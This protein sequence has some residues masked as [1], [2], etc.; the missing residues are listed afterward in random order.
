M[1]YCTSDSH[2]DLTRTGSARGTQPGLL[3]TQ[4]SPRRD[5]SREGSAPGDPPRRRPSASPD[6]RANRHT[7]PREEEASDHI[8]WP[9]HTRGSSAE[10]PVILLTTSTPTPRGRRRRRLPHND[11]HVLLGP[12]AR[13]RF[14]P[15]LAG[16][17]HAERG[18]R[19]A[20]LRRFVRDDDG[21]AAHPNRRLVAHR[22][23]GGVLLGK[24]DVAVALAARRLAPRGQPHVRDR[25]ALRSEHLA[26]VVFVRVVRQVADVNRAT[27]LGSRRGE[28][29][30]APVLQLGADGVGPAYREVPR[31]SVFD[32]GEPVARQTQRSLRCLGVGEINVRVPARLTRVLVSRE[33]HAPDAAAAELGVEERRERALVRRVRHAR[34]VHGSSRELLGLVG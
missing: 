28:G 8:E 22:D 15:R 5:P 13:F 20:R 17:L 19:S 24:L 1:R 6:T 34:D 31:A 11:G 32:R 29:V 26:H 30:A 12:L 33:P 25:P 23:L 9:Q 14:D 10:S 2:C 3:K 21:S 16:R 18:A 7:T 4:K 27:P